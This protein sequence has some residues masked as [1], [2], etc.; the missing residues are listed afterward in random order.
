MVK[1]DWEPHPILPIP[2]KAEATRL[3][4]M[5]LLDDFHAQ[6]CKLI[7]LEKLDPFN[8]GADWHNTEQFGKAGLFFHWKDVDAALDDPEVRLIFIFGGN[9]A[10]KSYY[11]ASRV[12]RF[13]ANKRDL[14]V[15]CCHSSNDTSI[16]SQ[17][18]FVWHNLPLEWK[19]ARR[20]VRATV[21]IGFSQ[22][23]GFSNRTFVAPNGSQCW[24]KNYTQDLSTLEGTELDLIWMD[25]LVP[26]AWVETLRYRLVTRRGKMVV[27]FT[28]IHGYTPTVKEA[29]DGHIIEDT[30]PA[31]LLEGTKSLIPGVPDG[32]MPFRART[33]KGGKI[34]W[35]FTEWNPYNPF[36]EMAATLQGSIRTEIEIRAYG[37]VSNP[38][39]G[40]FPRFG[41]GN[42]IEP[43]QVPKKGT[44]YMVVD[45]TSGD[46]NWFMLW[47]RVDEL[48]RKF[49]YREWPNL[50]NYGEWALPSDKLDG[51]KGPAQTADC[52]RDLQQYKRLIRDLEKNDGPILIRM[53]DPRAG[54]NAV[55]AQRGGNRSLIDMLADPVWGA[56][57]EIAEPGMIFVPASGVHIDEGCQLI[58][59]LLGWDQ[60]KEASVLNE[61]RLY[62]SKNCGN[63]IYSLRTWTGE[64]KDKGASK[65]PVDALRYLVL[66]DPTYVPRV[67]DQ[68]D[69]PGS[70]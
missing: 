52:G 67:M 32:H 6:R 65:D 39:T 37:Y 18:P 66:E 16:Q 1:L 26:L 21:N 30:K 17:Q 2:T 29:M 64:D 40:K 50:D 44:N 59:D 25:E 5:G 43:D 20:T 11:M 34:F 4:E 15:W 62:I 68:P 49:V 3:A 24:F 28:P 36:D 35:F 51:K 23:N 46:R 42:I 58:N 14:R 31:K 13:M 70:Y 7:E 55:V 56:D 54:A 10:S 8:F 22:K 9:R 47:L 61:P 41:D 19:N 45:P 57:G 12:V 48:G 38:V 33:R 63:L 27:T 69:D 60:T 53:I